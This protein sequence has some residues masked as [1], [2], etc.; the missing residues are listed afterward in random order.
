[1]VANIKHFVLQFVFELGGGMIYC[2]VNQFVTF[3]TIYYYI[4]GIIMEGH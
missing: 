3:F 1:M 4:Q 2:G